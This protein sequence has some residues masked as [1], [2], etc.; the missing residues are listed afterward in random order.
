MFTVKSL[1]GEN[2]LLYGLQDR[3]SHHGNSERDGLLDEHF[4]GASDSRRSSLD[5]S[6]IV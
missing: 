5:G 4:H 1:V 2:Y 6:S 3:V